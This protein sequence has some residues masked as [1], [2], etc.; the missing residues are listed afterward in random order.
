MDYIILRDYQHFSRDYLKIE[1]KNINKEALSV[2]TTYYNNRIWNTFYIQTPLFTILDVVATNTCH[3]MYVSIKNQKFVDII[4][5]IDTSV[6]SEIVAP[7]EILTTVDKFIP[8]VKIDVNSSKHEIFR[9]DIPIVHGNPLI[10]VYDDDNEELSFL[11]L[12]KG[13]R[14]Y[15]IIKPHIFTG[16]ELRWE[17]PQIKVSVPEHQFDNCVLSDDGDDVDGN[18][19]NDSD[20][21]YQE[22]YVAI[23][24]Q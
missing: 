13:F 21:E 5:E 22:Y 3:M 17:I 15:A 7:C 12:D 23:K 1:K 6:I 10:R 20:I 14:G 24:K 2:T 9:F 8:S 16:T 4:N 19:G 11:T 18:D